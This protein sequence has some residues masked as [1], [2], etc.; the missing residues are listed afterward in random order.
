MLILAD[1][2]TCNLAFS[3]SFSCTPGLATWPCHPLRIKNVISGRKSRSYSPIFSNV[4]IPVRRAH[5]APH[6]LTVGFSKKSGK[7]F[8]LGNIVHS[9]EA[10][11]HRSQV[12]KSSAFYE[13]IVLAREFEPQHAGNGV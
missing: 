6:Y 1:F 10:S 3:A 11:Y 12:I 13:C 7:V 5:S 2:A 8:Y 9:T 4:Q